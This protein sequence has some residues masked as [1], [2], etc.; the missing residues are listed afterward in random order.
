MSKIWL[1]TGSGQGLGRRSWKQRWSEA[2]GRGEHA[3]GGGRYW[4]GGPLWRQRIAVG[5]GRRDRAALP[6]HSR[7]LWRSLAG[8]RRRKQRSEGASG[9]VEEVT[10][11][12]VRDLV[13]TNLLGTVWVTQAA[14]PDHAGTRQR[15]YHSSLVGWGCD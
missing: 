5:A 12:E 13:D 1:V 3:E 6:P 15:A 2:I 10:E 14:L 11:A 9:A 8:S 7:L 4:P